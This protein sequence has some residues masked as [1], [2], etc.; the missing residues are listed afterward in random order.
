[1]S[2]P[3]MAKGN[4]LLYRTQMPEE[5]GNPKRNRH[6][7]EEVKDEIQSESCLFHRLCH[8]LCLCPCHLCLSLGP[9][10]CGAGKGSIPGYGKSPSF[11][12]GKFGSPLAGKTRRKLLERKKRTEVFLFSKK[13]LWLSV[14]YRSCKT[15]AKEI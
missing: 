11:L 7:S 6:T 1:M 5:A 4:F 10:R 3:K 12:P 15:Q 2:F 8:S 9:L 14:P 13:A